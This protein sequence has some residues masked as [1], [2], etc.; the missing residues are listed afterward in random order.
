MQKWREKLD[1]KWV[2]LIVCF[3]MEFV[4]LGFCSSNSGLYL[5]PIT[6]ALEIPRSLYSFNESI[7]YV[8]QT[9]TA[10]SFGT[11]TQHFGL[12]KPV[13]VSL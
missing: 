7:R 5:V 1:Y 11:I 9:L 12:K 13:C 4:C 2:I 10:L 6:T 8:V 3:F